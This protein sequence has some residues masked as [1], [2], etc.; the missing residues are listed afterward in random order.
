M[1]K[2]DKMQGGVDGWKDELKTALD[3][4]SEEWMGV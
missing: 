2:M 4:R 3:G 1:L